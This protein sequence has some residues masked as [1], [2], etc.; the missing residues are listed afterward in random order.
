MNPLVLYFASGETL[1]IG[2]GILLVTIILSPWAKSRWQK[3]LRNLAAIVGLLLMILS[4]APLP[5]ILYG[6]LAASFIAWLIAW[7]QTPKKWIRTA[8][9]TCLAVTI[10]TA[11]AMELPHRHDRI[12]TQGQHNHLTII[13]DSIS[14]G[15]KSGPTWSAIY[16]TKGVRIK[17]L[18]R[19]GI[20]VGEAMPMAR[21]MTPQDTLILIELGG[22]DLLMDVAAADFEQDLDRLLT[23]IATPARQLVMM[24]L[25]LLPH[26]IPFGQIQRRLAKKY[27]VLLIP[28]RHFIQV[29]SGGDATSDGLHLSL[30]GMMKMSKLV[31]RFV[32]QTLQKNDETRMTN[33]ESNPND[34]MFE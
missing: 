34:R 31:N 21:K 20:V 33:D 32:G 14:A 1:Y 3:R 25:P 12:L 2:G 7:N 24:E 29:L 10:T 9:A 17:N 26:K 5:W 8:T 27:N 19:A 11:I 16:S 4:C 18:S 28:K 30:T 23:A 15:I 6:G 22:N 13:G